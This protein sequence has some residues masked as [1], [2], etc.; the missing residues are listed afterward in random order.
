MTLVTFLIATE[1]GISICNHL[2]TYLLSLMILIHH[3]DVGGRGQVIGVVVC[4]NLSSR[5]RRMMFAS[6]QM[7]VLLSIPLGIW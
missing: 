6:Q 4:N 5:N 7:I 3:S 1:C 2:L